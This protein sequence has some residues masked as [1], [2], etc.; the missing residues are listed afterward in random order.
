MECAV[1]AAA[2]V[3][4]L[5][6]QDRHHPLFTAVGCVRLLQLRRSDPS[7]LASLDR[8]D[9]KLAQLKSDPEIVENL[10]AVKAV[11]EPYQYPACDIEDAYSLIRLYG[12]TL[13]DVEDS[14]VMSH[15]CH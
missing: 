15:Y 12:Y 8:L 14:K 5:S 13:P 2:P 3:S 6:P 4:R 11:L 7:T 10:S 9:R 1:L